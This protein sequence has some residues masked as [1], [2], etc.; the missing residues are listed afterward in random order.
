MNEFIED[1][2]KYPGSY[3]IAKRLNALYR[4]KEYRLVS[5]LLRRLDDTMPDYFVETATT[6][7]IGTVPGAMKDAVFR[8]IAALND[9]GNLRDVNNE[10][11][12]RI[13]TDAQLADDLTWAWIYLNQVLGVNVFPVIIATTEK[14]PGH[15][16]TSVVETAGMSFIE[17]LSLF[18]KYHAIGAKQLE[19]L[20]A[21]NIRRKRNPG[22]IDSQGNIFLM[23]PGLDDKKYEAIGFER[24]TIADLNFN[25]YTINTRTCPQE[26][27]FE[28]SQLFD[29]AAFEQMALSLLLSA[30]GGPVRNI[31]EQAV[32]WVFGTTIEKVEEELNAF[33]DA[34]SKQYNV[35]GISEI[36]AIISNV[37]PVVMFLAGRIR[38]ILK[39]FAK[40]NQKQ[41]AKK[42][43]DRLKKEVKKKTAESKTLISK[44]GLCEAR[45]MKEFASRV[46]P[47][48]VL[49]V[50]TFYQKS[51]TKTAA[52][53]KKRKG[54]DSCKGLFQTQVRDFLNRLL[55]EDGRYIHG[56]LMVNPLLLDEYILQT[57]Q[58][59]GAGIPGERKSYT[60]ASIRN[61]SSYILDFLAVWELT[62]PLAVVKKITPGAV[63]LN[64]LAGHPDVLHFQFEDRTRNFKQ[65]LKKAE[66]AERLAFRRI[67]LK[68]SISLWYSRRMDL[69]MVRK[70]ESGMHN[71]I[72]VEFKAGTASEAPDK[73]IKEVVYDVRNMAPA[74]LKE[75]MQITGRP[76]QS[77]Y[78]GSTG[79]FMTSIWII[80]NPKGKSKFRNIYPGVTDLVRLGDFPIMDASGKK[81]RERIIATVTKALQD[82]GKKKYRRSSGYE[83]FAKK[84]VE[85]HKVT[86]GQVDEAVFRVIR[87]MFVIFPRQFSKE[88]KGVSRRRKK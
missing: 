37:V 86:I 49:A 8:G 14:A 44:I 35:E 1:L 69:S 57:A 50:C 79:S 45:L 33:L 40:K 27:L 62:P 23:Y 56:L 58:A 43:I 31:L 78:T 59:L 81:A 10:L 54:A 65:E 24:E 75:L 67:R 19:G 66:L 64:R 32:E 71:R 41:L 6:R 22:D 68:S 9:A 4:S 84:M 76:L 11:Y 46:L 80:D 39:R 88:V 83:A 15:S 60:N 30:F 72:E 28:Q 34:L 87:K 2:I 55:K 73:F 42:Q 82:K 26:I 74:V 16:C 48:I 21:K 13:N 70:E 25:I 3:A 7:F 29:T 52:S 53:K 51:K 77:S 38:N 85:A 18:L 63:A 12:K 17:R 5:G 20:L 47:S 61:A 36:K